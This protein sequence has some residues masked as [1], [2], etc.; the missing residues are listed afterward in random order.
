[1][2]VSILKV[3]VTLKP[4]PYIAISERFYSY[5]YKHVFTSIL[6]K[7]EVEENCNYLDTYPKTRNNLGTNTDFLQ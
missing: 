6:N 3:L 4:L 5:Y 1:M 2:P 7:I